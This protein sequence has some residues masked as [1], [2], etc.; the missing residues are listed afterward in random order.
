MIWVFDIDGTIDSNP[1]WYRQLTYWL[2]KSPSSNQIVIITCRNPKRRI[3]TIMHLQSWGILYDTLITM[4]EE[5]P[6][7]HKSL[8]MWKL[9]QV[10]KIKPDVWFD[11]EIKLYDQLYAIELINE[12]PRTE[13]V[14][15]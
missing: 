7:D 1:D 6:R 13:M 10:K 14:T 8:L 9:G 2:K 15:V 11:D 5:D 3:E 4:E 12:L